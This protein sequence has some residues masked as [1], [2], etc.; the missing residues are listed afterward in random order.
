MVGETVIS[1]G[2]SKTF[3]IAVSPD[4]TAVAPE[5]VARYEVAISCQFA[6]GVYYD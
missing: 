4:T 2:G 5:Q 3:P 6:D 1:P